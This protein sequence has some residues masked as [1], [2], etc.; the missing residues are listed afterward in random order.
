MISSTQLGL[1]RNVVDEIALEAAR[2]LK[3]MGLGQDQSLASEIAPNASG[4][5][6]VVDMH[7]APYDEGPTVIW[8]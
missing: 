7:F 3:V 2:I 4:R 5:E 1:T 6:G 8:W